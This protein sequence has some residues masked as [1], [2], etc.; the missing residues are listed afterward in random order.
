MKKILPLSAITTIFLLGSAH[1]ALAG[2]V[3][4]ES[5]VPCGPG[6]DHMC[7]LCDFVLMAHNIF[8]FILKISLATAILFIAIAGI[9]YIV[10]AGSEQLMTTAK[11]AMTY[12]LM[13][14][15]FCLG[16]WLLV[17]VIASSL[18][19]SDWNTIAIKD[20]PGFAIASFEQNCGKILGNWNPVT[21]E[22]DPPDGMKKYKGIYRDKTL[23]PKM[24][25][26]DKGTNKH[27]DYDKNACECDTGYS[28]NA[29][30][31]CVNIE[32]WD[33]T[34][35]WPRAVEALIWELGCPG[36]CDKKI[37]SPMYIGCVPKPSCG[38]MN[39]E[40]LGT[41][42]GDEPGSTCQ[43]TCQFEEDWGGTSCDNSDCCKKSPIDPAECN[44]CSSYSTD[45]AN[46]RLGDQ[47][48]CTKVYYPSFGTFFAERR[49]ECIVSGGKCISNPKHCP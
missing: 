27:W 2:N 11:S 9:L 45:I 19:Y 40:A 43:E 44:R 5:L 26:C 3:F 46:H 31:N 23:I 4:I 15:G 29:D 7:T 10:S 37:I 33:C 28:K 8:W 34:D 21:E 22:C 47:N 39:L 36:S 24:E 20:C 42:C 6:Q 32:C 35:R 16:A 48:Y 30:N 41:P 49:E 13:G 38:T 25:A 14:F 12:A 17:Q 18:G 1:I